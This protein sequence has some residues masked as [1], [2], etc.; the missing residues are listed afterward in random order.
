MSPVSITQ[1]CHSFAGDGFSWNVCVGMEAQNNLA[2]KQGWQGSLASLPQIPA[3]LTTG[4]THG[5]T[6]LGITVQSRLCQCVA[7]SLISTANLI[8][9][10]LKFHYLRKTYTP[11]KERSSNYGQKSPCYNRE[12]DV[13]HRLK[14]KKKLPV[15]FHDVLARPIKKR[16][17][18]PPPPADMYLILLLLTTSQDCEYI[19]NPPWT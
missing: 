19:Q 15:N 3:S 2:W 5:P 7:V 9:F 17:Y 8:I 13:A 12:P 10:I 16:C 14:K 4:T 18:S 1:K 11:L 6:F